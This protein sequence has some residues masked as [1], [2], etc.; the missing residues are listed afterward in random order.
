MS[1]QEVNPNR[2]PSGIV[3]EPTTQKISSAR[4]LL[5]CWGFVVLI[6]WVVISLK[7]N[8]LSK[9]D[10]SVVTIIGILTGGKAVQRFGEN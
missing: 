9:V 3:R 7:N 6:V 10:Q 2:Y 5:L 1:D 8:E 4:V